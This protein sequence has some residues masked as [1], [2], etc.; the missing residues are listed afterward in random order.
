MQVALK[1]VPFLVSMLMAIGM[2]RGSDGLRLLTE[3]CRPFLD[4]IG[5]PADLLPLV[6][7]RP[8]SG[9]GTQG[10]F[11]DLLNHFNPDGLIVRTAGTIFG[12]TET[13]FYVL[14]VYFGSVAVRRT[15]H[16][17]A[18]GLI[19]DLTGVV[20]SILICRWMFGGR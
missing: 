8:L 6:L 14:A 11:V 19:A 16:A 7:M 17:V 13:T 18:A 3:R 10:I 4:W 12:S 9:G 1:I 2:F 5:F 20:V 15:R